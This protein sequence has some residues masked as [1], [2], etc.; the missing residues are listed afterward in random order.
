MR[1][2]VF[3]LLGVEIHVPLQ[4]VPAN[5][6]Q[7]ANRAYEILLSGVHRDVLVDIALLR[8]FLLA[9]RTFEFH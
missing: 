4:L 6:G 1:A 8:Q 7:T 3:L 2:A 9:D 5:F